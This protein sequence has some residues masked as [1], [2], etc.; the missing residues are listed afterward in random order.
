[1]TGAVIGDL[2]AWTWEHDKKML[3]RKACVERREIVRIW[4]APY[5]Y[6]E[7]NL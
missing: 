3:L 1:M 6:V 5:C 7:E 4:T 2:A